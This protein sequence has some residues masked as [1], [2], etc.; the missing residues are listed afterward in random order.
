MKKNFNIQDAYLNKIRKHR[1]P[2]YI[3]IKNDRVF[4]GYI[5]AFDNYCILLKELSGGSPRLIFKH[6]I[7]YIY[8]TKDINSIINIGEETSST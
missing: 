6:S 8:P 2:V 5:T 1:V 4:E 7:S 3:Q